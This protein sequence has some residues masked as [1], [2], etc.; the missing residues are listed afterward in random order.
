VFEHEVRAMCRMLVHR[1]PDEEGVYLGAGVGLGMRRLSIID[2]D[3]SQQPIS[4]EDR[5]VWVVFNGEIYN[6]LELRQDLSRRGH[7]L[8]T[9]GDTETIVHLY[10]EFGPGCVDHLRGMFSFAIWDA[11]ERRL[12]LARDRLGIKPL[13]YVALP[14]GLA[15]ASELKP[16]LQL[17]EV[18]RKLSWEAVRHL[19]TFMA[20]PSAQSIV[21]GVQKLEPGRVATIC[22]TGDLRIH[23]Y[24]DLSFQP[25]EEASEREL[26]DRLRDLL[27]ESVK[28]HEVSDVPIGAFLSGGIDSSAVV[29]TMASM[30]A[31]PVK[32]FSIGFAEAEYDELVHARHVADTYAT[33]HHELVLRPDVIGLAEDLA[34]FLDEPFGDTSAI[35]TYMVSKLAAEHVTVV[36]TGDGGDELFGG[37][38]KYLTDQAEQRFDRIPR[39]IRRALGAVGRRMPDGAKGKRFLEHLALEGPNRFLDA[40]TL[41]RLDQLRKLFQDEAYEQM[42][43]HDP[44]T[45]ALGCLDRED[46]DGLSALQYCDLNTYLPLD[47]LT[48]VDRMAMAHSLEARPP[49]LDHKLVEFAATIPSRFRIRD[50]S[51]KYL[52]KQAMRGILPDDIIDRPKHGFAIPLARWFRGELAGFARDLL[53]SQ[54]AQQRGLFRTAQVERLI[55][56]HEG[57]RDIDLQ[58]WT[59]V[60][61]ELWCRRVLDVPVSSGPRPERASQERILPAVLA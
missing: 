55:R 61:L 12:L 27:C 3:S 38:D 8:R 43:A 21:D 22:E 56:L 14:H 29:A 11:A 17:P 2:L 10:E 1:G 58:L 42:S 33:E 37:Y 19:V 52:F 7:R 31:E 54:R 35:P 15:F 34:W 4:N 36:L 60:S 26:V 41:F 53:C 5:S 44:W 28:L 24:W 59:L 51:T 46:L 13:Y 16:L 39:S 25:N 40:S 23:R 48:K 49:L 32:T 18:G 20:T 47:I 57:G 30:R 9:S 50:G 6:Y 45:Q